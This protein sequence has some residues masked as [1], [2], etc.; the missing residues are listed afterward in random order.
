MSIDQHR[1]ADYDNRAAVPDYADIFLRWQAAAA[2]YRARKTALGE[3]RLDVAYGPDPRHTYDIFHAPPDGTPRP[4]TALFIHGGYWRALDKSYFSHM[5]AGLNAHGYDVALMNYRL[6]PGVEIPDIMADARAAAEHLARAFDRPLLPF[7]HSAGG[8]LVSHL[9][10]TDWS[11]LDLPADLTAAGMVVSGLYDLR[12]LAEISVNAD[13]KLTSATVLTA[14]PLLG[15]VPRLNDLAVVVGG[16]ELPPFLEQ[17]QRLS[18]LWGA[19]AQTSTLHI[20]DGANHFTILDPFE[21]PGSR[22]TARLAEMG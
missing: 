5:A 19:A 20:V 10:T 1:E 4:R 6:C 16:A 12:P 13:L 18:S 11:A 8:H 2:D 9:L 15:P 7:G 14:S 22:L 21:D 3:T 17:N